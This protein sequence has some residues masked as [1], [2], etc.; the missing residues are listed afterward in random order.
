MSVL[1][2][3]RDVHSVSAAPF[4]TKPSSQVD[5][6]WEPKLNSP[7]GSEQ[8]KEPWE[9]ELRVGHLFAG[10]GTQRGRDQQDI[11]ELHVVKWYQKEM[12][13]TDYE[14]NLPKQ[15]GMPALHMPRELHSV[16]AVPFSRKPSSQV[17]VHWEPKLKWPFGS[18][19]DREPWGGS[20]IGLHLFTWRNTETR[21]RSVKYTLHIQNIQRKAEVAMKTDCGIYSDYTSN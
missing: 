5:L 15:C 4:N 16:L 3:P 20:L 12:T 11:L 21:E 14:T 19:Q 8:N 1:H 10:K 6:H 13:T 18:E 7:W 17:D 2:V 9:G